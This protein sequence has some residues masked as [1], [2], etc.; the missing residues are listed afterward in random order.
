[1]ARSAQAMG[2]PWGGTPALEA[3]NLS[4]SYGSLAAVDGVSFEVRPGEI[5]GVLGPNGAGKTTALQLCLGLLHADA[6]EAR[7]FGLDP[8][9]LSARRPPG[10]APDPPLFPQALSGPRR[11]G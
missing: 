2:T 10:Y 9:D 7:L 6:G 1:M 5:V 4:K 8:E 11:L 3:K